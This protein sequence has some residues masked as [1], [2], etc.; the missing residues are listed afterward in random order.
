MPVSDESLQWLGLPPERFLNYARS[1]GHSSLD[2]LPGDPAVYR[3]GATFLIAQAHRIWLTLQALD[4]Y[5]PDHPEWA[6]LDLGAYPFAI[7][8]AIRNFLRRKCRIVATVAQTLSADGLAILRQNAVELLPVNLDPRVKMEAPLPGMTDY[9]PLPASSVDV[10]IF[11]HVIE[12]LYHP[13]QILQEVARVLKPGGKL[14]LSTDNGFLLGGFLNYLNAGAYLH[15][16]VESTAAMVFTEW[17]GHVRFYTEGDLRSLLKAVGLK[18]IDCQLWE[19]LYNS[20]PEEYFIEPNTRLPRWRASLLTDFPVFRNEVILVAEKEKEGWSERLARPFDASSNAAE[21]RLLGEELANGRCEGARS[22]L[23]DLIFGCRLLY[24]RWPTAEELRQYPDHPPS[25][26]IEGLVH[27][28]LSSPEFKAHALGVQL[29]RPGP[30]CIVMT[31]TAGGLRFFFSAQDTFVGFPVAVG[32]YEPD[33]SSALDRLLRPGMN[34]IDIGANFGLYSVRAAVAVR[35]AGGK[36]FSFEPDPFSYSLLL[37]NCAENHVEDAVTTFA[38]AC[39]DE[40]TDVGI[41]RHPNPSNL[42]GTYVRKQGQPPG[43][44]AATGSAALR[45]LDD[46]IPADIRIDLVKIDAEGYERFALRGMRRILTECHPAIICEFSTCSLEFE[47]PDAPSGLLADLTALGYSVYEASAFGK[48]Q[49][50]LFQ[51]P[52]PG[53]HFANLV[54]LPADESPDKYL[55]AIG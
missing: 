1:Q 40:N 31:E 39:G 42:G 33:V 20:V 29:E 52:G 50:A 3:A 34:C 27:G 16:P 2:A 37:K 46:M 54:C 43:A 10:A 6:V 19:V 53:V 22:T 47:S 55:R 26:G 28:L 4:R 49:A 48:G 44:G 12:H 32:V 7:D 14:V 51:N 17:R 24:G 8:L 21:L 9:V 38:V 30:S 23:L 36:V 18:V 45:R 35:P 11:A 15:E 25:R 41:Y 5:L 13:I